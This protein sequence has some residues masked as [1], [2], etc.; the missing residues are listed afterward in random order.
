M[1]A[2]HTRPLDAAS[3]RKATVEL[4]AAIEKLRETLEL[5]R[6]ETITASLRGQ[7]RALRAVKRWL[8]GEAKNIAG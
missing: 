8:S 4:D 2:E 7:I 1:S 3:E 5:D 6:S